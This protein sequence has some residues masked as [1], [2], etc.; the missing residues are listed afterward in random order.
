MSVMAS[1]M[2]GGPV[3]PAWAILP[4]GFLTLVVIGMHVMVQFRSPM[5][6]S[7][8]RIR[9]ANGL[10]MMFAVPLMAFGISVVDPGQQPRLFALAWVVAFCLVV[11]IALLA[12]LDGLNNVRIHRLEQKQARDRAAALRASMRISPREASDDEPNV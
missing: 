10:L 9:I 3:A 1:S 5:P 7:R 2:T 8:R 4:I 6:E 12:V 11:L